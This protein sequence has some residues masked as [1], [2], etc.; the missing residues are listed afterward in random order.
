[1]KKCSLDGNN[2]R[3]IFANE[4]FRRSWLESLGWQKAAIFKSEP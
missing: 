4:A 2:L 1:V 3:G